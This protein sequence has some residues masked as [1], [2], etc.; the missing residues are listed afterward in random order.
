[1]S[2]SLKNRRRSNAVFVAA[3]LFVSTLFLSAFAPNGNA[4]APADS[5]YKMERDVYFAYRSF[6]PEHETMR[7]FAERG[8]HT[9]CVFPANTDNS[10]GEPYGKY[11][12]IWRYPGKYDW[13]S[14]YRQFD[15]IIAFDPKAEFL[16]M[17]DL[18]SPTWLT[19]L[20]AMKDGDGSFDSFVDIVNCLASDSW[21]AETTRYLEDFLQ[22]TEKRYGDRIRAYVLACGQTDEWM[23]YS[24]NR[25]SRAWRTA[26]EKWSAAKNL[27]AVATPIPFSRYDAATFENF[28]RDPSKEADVLQT[29]RFEQELVV[30]SI[31]SFAKKTKELTGGE[32]E[33]G[34]FFGYIM[35]LTLN[36]MVG[37]CHLD[38]ERLFAA[39][40]VDFFISPGTYS[41]RQIGAGSGFMIPNE[42]RLL[43]G[44]GFVHEIDQRVSTYNF[45]LNE[46]VSIA[47]TPWRDER[48]DVAGL[49]REVCLA[50][51]DHSSLWFFDMWGG[52]F[53]NPSALD[54]LAAMKKV[55]DKHSAD[56]SR[57]SAEIL[58]VVDPQSCEL[59]SDRNLYCATLHVG[60]RNA[61]NR[62]G[63]P[64]AVCSFNDLSQLDLA[65]FKLLVMTDEYLIT[66]ER[67]KLLRDRVLRDGRTILWLGAPGICDGNDLD[68]ARVRRW[69]GVEYETPTQNATPIRRD[70]WTSVY[71]PR[72]DEA[73]SAKLREIARAAGVHIYWEEFAP[74]YANRKLLAAHVLEGGKKKISLPTE[75]RKITE[76]FSGR[77]VAENADSFEY[78]FASPETALFEL[79]K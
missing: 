39:P 5:D 18:N 29:I 66:P 28:V 14:L 62:V 55:W 13:D 77:V 59:L 50:L 19:R 27:P 53:D 64:F 2:P 20:L 16:C 38:Y 69:T 47:G 75:Y 33:V 30:D 24:A 73:T 8:V 58:L 61:L 42:T 76:A 68:V 12:A 45:D 46:F 9:Y 71:L 48:E 52:S 21:R 60:V 34:V 23:N 63:A 11:P 7:K 26:F 31:L 70:G 6:W 1:M 10:L 4:D 43:N 41:D 54:N 49:R 37:S 3:F 78:D 15:E 35:E 51:I 72:H 67:E 32:K 17:V 57:T 56:R 36:R 22:R 74:I 40:E 25:S 79:E 65:Q 44:K